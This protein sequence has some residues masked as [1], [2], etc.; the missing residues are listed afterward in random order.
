MAVVCLLCGV[1]CRWG[2]VAAGGRTAGDTAGTGGLGFG[3]PVA[4]AVVVVVVVVV[5]PACVPDTVS[6]TR[7]RMQAFGP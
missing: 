5:A 3:V 6:T 4:K 2:V 1:D 7:I